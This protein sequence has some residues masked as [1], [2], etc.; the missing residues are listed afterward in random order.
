MVAITITITVAVSIILSA[1]LAFLAATHIERIAGVV[2][3]QVGGVL[4]GINALVDMLA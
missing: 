4:L 3:L 1:V 2:Q